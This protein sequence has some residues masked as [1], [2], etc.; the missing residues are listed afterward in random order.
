MKVEDGLRGLCCRIIT[1]RIGR[2]RGRPGFGNARAVENS[3]ATIIKRQAG[4]LRKERAALAPGEPKPNDLFLTKQDVIG[5]EPSEA[6]RASTALTRHTAS[7]GAA[8]SQTPTKPLL[9]ILS[10]P[11][12]RASLVTIAAFF[13]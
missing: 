11:K 12:F 8:A 13:S 4:R 10:S 6:L 2:V 5:P 9:L 3:L 1:R 7:T